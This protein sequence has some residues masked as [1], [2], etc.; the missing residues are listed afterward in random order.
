VVPQNFLA[1]DRDQ[2]LLLPP[3]LRDWLG[4]DHLAWCVLD[5][6]EQVDLSGIYGAYRADGWGRAAFDPQMMVALLLYAYAVGERSSRMIE[7]RC[8]EDV[9]FRVISAN[10]V[11]DHATIARFRARHEQALAGLFTDVLELCAKAGLVSVGLVALDGTKIEANAAL[12]QT[13]SYE[14]INAEMTQI[15]SEAANTDAQE[16]S[17]FGAGS[18]GDELPPA[19]AERQSRRARLAR[20]KA[21]LESEHAEREQTFREHMRDRERWEQKTGKKM[22]GR[23]PQPPE[24]GELTLAKLN[25]TDPDS[26]VMKDKTRLVQGYNAQVIA[27]PEQVILAAALTQD[28]NDSRQ[29]PPM[30]A[31]AV[32]T[33]KRAGISEPLGTVVADGGYW[34]ERAVRRIQGQGVAVLVPPFSQANA[35]KRKTA[36]PH[37][38]AAKRMHARLQEPDAAHAHRRRKQIVEPVFANT[39]TIPRADRFVRRGLPACEAEWQLIATTHNL[40]KLWRHR[41]PNS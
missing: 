20:C 21:E 14:S 7:R 11:P 27:S 2:E 30:V 38:E 22:T 33:L 15:L 13:R 9:A 36:K 39:K 40:L 35:S 16:D 19:L 17:Q 41:R 3:S 8:V 6:V 1:C 5:A 26:R 29:L 18:R 23:K 32:R 4:E 25:V 34:S 28:P 37:G 24:P 10:R 31:Q 12:G